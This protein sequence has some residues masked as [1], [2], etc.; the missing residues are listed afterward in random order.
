MNSQSLFLL[1][2]VALV[3][4]PGAYAED[5]PKVESELRPESVGSATDEN[6]V[7]REEEAQS[8]DGFSVKEKKVLEDSFTKFE[9][10]AEVGRLMDIIINSLY[11]KKEIFLR[12]LI[13]NASDALDKIRF[14]S[15]AD[16]SALGEG[17]NAK[18]DIRI[19]LDK[20][21]KTLSI[22]DRGIGMSKQHLIDNLGTI[23]KSGTSSFLEAM[24]KGGDLNLIG[25]FGVGFYSVYLVADEVTVT[26]K[27]NG[28]PQQVW[29]SS[30]DS[31]FSIADDPRG[32]TLGRGTRITLHLKEDATEFLEEGGV[33]NLVKRYSEFINFPIY[34]LVTKETEV[35]VPLDEEELKKAEEEEAAKK[36]EEEEA[37]KLDGD[38][39]EVKEEDADEE[40][41][42]EKPKTK[43]V[44]EVSK[45]WELLNE[46][47]AIWTRNPKEVEDEDYN[48]FFKALTKDFED[49]LSHIHFTA[50]GEVEFR[51]ILYIPSKPPADMFEKT[52]AQNNNVRLYVR[53]V[54]ITDEFDDLLPRYLNFLKGVVDSEDLPLNVSREMLQQSR[55]LKVIKKKLVTKALEM[56]RRLS[57]AEEEAQENKAKRAESGDKA[58][59]KKEDDE[60]EDDEED[61]EKAIEE[62]KK[63][64]EAFGKNLKLGVIEDPKNRKK[65][66]KLLRYKTSHSK[67]QYIS[68]PTYVSRMKKGQKHIYFI[69]GESEK[70]VETSP[71][72]EKLEKL[73]YEVIYMTDPIDEYTVQHMDEF[74][75]FKL[76][77][78][79]KE[80]LKFGDKHEKKQKEKKEAAKESLK[81]LISWLKDLL[82]DQVEK[83]VVSNR[84]TSTPCVVVTGQYGYTANMERL[85][86]AQALNDPTK[87]NFMAAKKTLELNPNH[88]IVNELK[89][90]AE[91]SPED[92]TTKELAQ[93]LFDTA[94]ISAGFSIDDQVGFSKRINRLLKQGLSLDLDAEATQETIEAEEVEEEQPAAASTDEEEAEEIDADAA[95]PKEDL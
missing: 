62:Y 89:K 81:G 64:L 65:L 57:E 55:V 77:N 50:E 48:K 83:V 44:K 12:E 49:P 26:S 46:Q 1:F 15:I 19:E 31:T 17:D 75:D 27:H 6:L 68:L 66:A 67:G 30:S 11:S 86:K 76:A 82:K 56:M 23:A 93:V 51:S 41:K 79:A 4:I 92:E 9:F 8:A 72:L 60:E 32:D 95:A 38:D 78:A 87:Y 94:A 91:E 10:Q 90:R 24:S 88:P 16:P 22:T 54:F 20:D 73:G 85:M 74:D 35:E 80:D 25:Q 69:A 39:V 2:V 5:T 3:V 58:E 53:R 47:K 40:D 34:L 13:S 45:E 61:D 59:E 84:L 70:E 29:R 43:K 37:K 52:N 36:A 14:Q 21:A 7:A 33:K 28:E 63:F 42:E 71:F 18:L